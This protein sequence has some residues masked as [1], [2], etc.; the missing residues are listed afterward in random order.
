MVISV[1]HITINSPVVL[2]PMSGVT[3]LPF[4]RQ[5]R[6]FGVG[7]VVSE[8]IASD[9]LVRERAD[10][11]RRVRQD[12][13][14]EPCAMQIAG[15]EA[16]WMAE[17]AIIAEGEGA[18]IIDINMGCPSKR[19][20][21]GLSG[22]ALMRDLDHAMTLIEATV[23]AVTVPV[24]L[25]M[26]TGWDDASRNA[27]E[28]ARRAESAG[29]Q[30][31]TVHGRTRCQFYDGRADWRFIRDVKDAV[32]I[33]VIANGDVTTGEEAASILRESGADGVMVGR[34][35]LGRPW[36]LCQIEHFLQKKTMPRS[37]S[38]V[39]QLES[40]V[41]QYWE[42]IELYGTPLGVRTARKHI[43][44]CI[45][46]ATAKGFL[47]RLIRHLSAAEFAGLNSRKRSLL[48]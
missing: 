35:A 15:R 18:Q 43:A 17:A 32:S 4:R 42:T 28:L 8:M 46:V 44:A 5:V 26:R 48:H 25:K 7:L 33:P 16:K 6:C 21:G 22:S 31:F 10:V 47:E 23:E 20:T 19:V 29:I 41:T 34:A 45:D 24:T 30:M 38:L 13:D 3:D 11:L 27:P 1:G 12:L 14:V 36:L 40:L 37:P 2:A 9:A 39:R